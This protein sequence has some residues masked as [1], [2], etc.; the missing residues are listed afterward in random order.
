MGALILQPLACPCCQSFSRESGDGRRGCLY[1]ARDGR[2]IANKEEKEGEKTREREDK[3]RQREHDK[4]VKAALSL[5]RK[6]EQEL[7]RQLAVAA[8]LATTSETQTQWL[9]AGPSTGL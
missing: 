8:Q 6:E 1:E 3:R 5:E 4:Q 7:R 9:S 2:Q